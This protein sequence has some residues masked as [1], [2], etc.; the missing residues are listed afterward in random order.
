MIFF[1]KTEPNFFWLL[2]WNCCRTELTEID[3]I[4]ARI[5]QIIR[6]HRAKHSYV[7]I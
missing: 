1:F 5:N 6:N 3:N 2:R 7:V 4:R